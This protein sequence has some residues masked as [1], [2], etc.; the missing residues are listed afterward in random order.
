MTKKKCNYDEH[1]E[2]KCKPVCNQVAANCI[3][4]YYYKYPK[5]CPT[6]TCGNLTI[7]EGSDEPP[8]QY[9]APDGELLKV[10][11]VSHEEKNTTSK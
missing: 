5:L 8:T 1:C 9:M 10:E 7:S 2:K 6:L 11:E 3:K 4:Y